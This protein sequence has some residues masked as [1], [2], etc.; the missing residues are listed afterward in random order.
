MMLANPYWLLLLAVIPLLFLFSQKKA[1]LQTVKLPDLSGIS[2]SVSWRVRLLPLLKLLRLISLVL[3]IVAMARP[4]RLWTEKEIK[5][6]GVDIYLVLDNSSSMLA[7][8]FRPNRLEASKE[9]A[10]QFIDRRPY[11]KIGLSVFAGESFTK[12]P[13]TTDHKVLKQMMDKIQVGLL[14]DGTAIGMGLGN[15][16]AR[17]SHSKSKSKVVVLLTDGVNNAGY[18]KPM[19]AARLAKENNIK[20]YTIG[21]GSQGQ[22]LSPV[23]RTRDGKFVFGMAKVE[24][25]EE[26]LR[27]M[28][29]ETGGKYY[30]ALNRADLEKIY[31]EIDQLEKSDIELHYIKHREDR[32]YP[33][34][35][36]GFWLLVIEFLLRI[37]VFRILP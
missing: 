27:H 5:G 2:S 17:L 13:A 15:A 8:D 14:T 23:S 3:L 37:F 9:V 7:Q 26:L 6:E 33:F 4:Q 12:C 31:D 30:R 21:V 18:I 32:Y 11:D 20:L 34:L 35:L 28:A 29:K 24:I 10:K 16:V 19:T 1:K 25:D 22:A 36:F